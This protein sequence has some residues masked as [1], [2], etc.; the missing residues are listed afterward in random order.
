V[1]DARPVSALPNGHMVLTARV[2]D[3]TGK[4]MSDEMELSAPTTGLPF[5]ARAARDGVGRFVLAWQE[6]SG[7]GE[8]R[9]VWIRRVGADGKPIGAQWNP[10]ESGENS[11]N[12]SVG[13]DFAGRFVAIYEQWIPETNRYELRLGAYNSDGSE[14]GTNVELVSPSESSI[15]SSPLVACDPVGNCVAAW[16]RLSID[17]SDASLWLASFSLSSPWSIAAYEFRAAS[18]GPVQL[19]NL[20][21]RGREVFELVWARSL[22]SNAGYALNAISLNSDAQPT[23]VEQL[24]QESRRSSN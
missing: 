13:A 6:I 11:R 24:V 10:S 16:E 18:E 14:H 19:R 9:E 21:S 23:G 12:I 5:A 7:G 17:A 1:I 22:H 20:V 8:R 3:S 4:A 15:D 2:F